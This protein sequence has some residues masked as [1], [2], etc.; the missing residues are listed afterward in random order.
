MLGR[1][2]TPFNHFFNDRI[3][4]GTLDELASKTG[5]SRRGLRALLNM[6]VSIELLT[7]DA[8]GRYALAPEAA[9]FLVLRALGA[10]ATVH[11]RF[12]PRPEA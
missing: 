8:Q 12:C 7:K 6:L 11:S 2:E 4:P 3:Y 9:A 5:T 10:A 1:M